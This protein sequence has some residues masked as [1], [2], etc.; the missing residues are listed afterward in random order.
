MMEGRL[1]GSFG[2]DGGLHDGQESE[3]MK[4]DGIMSKETR[5]MLREEWKLRITEERGESDDGEG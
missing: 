5:E 2:T 3:G 1:S 4:G